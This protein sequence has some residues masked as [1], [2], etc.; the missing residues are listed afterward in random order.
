[1]KQT[2]E[3]NVR[4]KKEENL[5][6]LK[7]KVAKSIVRKNKC[8]NVECLLSKKPVAST[9]LHISWKVKKEQKFFPEWVSVSMCL[10]ERDREREWVMIGILCVRVWEEEIE[11]VCVFERGRERVPCQKTRRYTYSEKN[12]IKENPTTFFAKILFFFLSFCFIFCA[13]KGKSDQ[14]FLK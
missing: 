4:G 1:M 6:F 13:I 2:T 9:Y 3:K 8:G 14:N 10:R 5:Q 11:K 12:S 7:K